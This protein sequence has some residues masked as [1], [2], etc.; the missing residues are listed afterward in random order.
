[1]DGFRQASCVARHLS[2]TY[3]AYL[4]ASNFLVPMPVPVEA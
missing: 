1:M 4:L 2:D 3:I